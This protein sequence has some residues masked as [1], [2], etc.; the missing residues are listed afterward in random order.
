[1]TFY[2]LKSHDKFC[3]IYDVKLHVKLQEMTLSDSVL[4]DTVAQNIF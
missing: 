4:F 3:I 1:M 2:P